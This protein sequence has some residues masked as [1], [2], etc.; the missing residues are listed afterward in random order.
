M[1]TPG[2]AARA[3]WCPPEGWGEGLPLSFGSPEAPGDALP[4]SSGLGVRKSQLV[5]KEVEV[6]DSSTRNMKPEEL[7]PRPRPPQTRGW[8]SSGSSRC[9]ASSGPRAGEGPRSGP[10]WFTIVTKHLRKP[11]SFPWLLPSAL[12]SPLGGGFCD[13]ST[14][15]SIFEKQTLPHV[16]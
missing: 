2:P 12:A 10:G 4:R 8:C 3:L 6:C 14:V 1:K 16:G 13:T 5:R 11:S 15:L 9:S 7:S